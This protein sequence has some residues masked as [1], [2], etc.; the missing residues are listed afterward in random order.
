MTFSFAPVGVIHA[1]YK[2]KFGIPRQPG[3][4]REAKSRLELLSPY[5]LPEA[6]EG[7]EGYSHIWIQFVFHQAM[8]SAWRPRVRPPRLG[9]NVRVGVFASRSPFRPNSIGL[10]VVKLESIDTS[11][12]V[13]LQLSGGDLLDGTP[14]LD[15][16]PYVGYADSIPDAL[17]GFASAPPERRLEVCFSPRSEEQITARQDERLRS[18]IKNLLEM[19]PRPAYSG[20]QEGRVYGIRLYDFDLRWRVVGDRLEVLELA[21]VD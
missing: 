19:D 12:G 16:K 20:E 1:P 9:G 4:V 6:V 5:N 21:E 14:V 18:F 17:S 13:S 7:L 11:G 8:R 15:I 10:S 2:E 3:L